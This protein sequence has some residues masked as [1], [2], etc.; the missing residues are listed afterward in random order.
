MTQIWYSLRLSE[1]DYQLVIRTLKE[2]ILASSL[3]ELT[4]GAMKMNQGQ[5]QR[6]VEVWRTW[7]QLSFREEDW[8]TEARDRLFKNF[9]AQEGMKLYLEEIPK[10]HKKSASDWFANGIL[11]PKESRKMLPREN[12]TLTGSNFQ[13]S[14]NKGPFTYIIQS[15]TT[16]FTG[17]DY[18]DVKQWGHSNSILKMYS[19]YVSHVLEKCA[20]KLATGR[21]K[22]HFLLCNCMEMTPFLPPGRKY[23]RVTT[24]NIADYVPLTRLL[25][26]C[27]PLLNPSNCSSVIITEFHNWV[28]H[29]NLEYEA[30]WRA[31]F[32]PQGDSFRKKVLKDTNDPAIAN[33]TAYQAFV[34]YHDHSAEFIQV[35]RAALMVSEI[36]DARNHRRTWTAVAD[37]NG[38]IA[39]DFLRCQN[40]VFPAKRMLN[41]RRVTMLNGFE[42]AV[43]WIAK[44]K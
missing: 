44:P 35:L 36:P 9:Q 13:V 30:K 34:E 8:I 37:Y 11:S 19:D 39:R 21:V 25:D 7:L 20:L 6:I 1:E 12:F 38:L 18:K 17:W 27:E 22:F 43:E 41:C 5:S 33:S 29:T 23:D 2:L 24:S 28:Q 40:R 32:M 10:E 15:S 42:R 31:N 4:N 3:E 14:G 26:T 16:P